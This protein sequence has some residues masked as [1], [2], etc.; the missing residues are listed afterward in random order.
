MLQVFMLHL[1]IGQWSGFKRKM[2]AAE[3]SAQAL[4]TVGV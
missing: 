2:E 4:L 3:S 1:D